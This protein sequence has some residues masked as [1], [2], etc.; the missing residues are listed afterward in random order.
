MP[1]P[2]NKKTQFSKWLAGEL[3]RLKGLGITQKEIATTTG[4]PESN[5]SALKTGTQ[6]L[7]IELA[8]TL[9]SSGYFATS[10]TQML[11]M[12]DE[13]RLSLPQRISERVMVF[14]RL[15][16]SLSEE[17]QNE[18]VEFMQWKQRRK[19]QKP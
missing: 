3:D 16:T 6:R 5:L 4:I 10:A 13:I 11:E 15:F 17:E 19:K 7:T 12:A 14:V 8:N 1:T 18:T 9:E 2:L